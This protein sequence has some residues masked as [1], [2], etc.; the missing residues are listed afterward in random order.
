MSVNIARVMKKDGKLRVCIE[1]RNLNGT[2]S[3]DEYPMSIA[4]I[5]VDVA[6]DHNIVSSMDNYSSYNQI[7]I[8]Q[9]DV[10]K[11]TFQSPNALGTYEWVLMAF[12]LKNARAIYKKD[13]NSIFHEFVGKLTLLEHLKEYLIECGNII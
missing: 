8:A 9:E 5:L 6:M 13:M 1:F 2:T 10:L 3:K 12:G 7:F 11:T 4:D